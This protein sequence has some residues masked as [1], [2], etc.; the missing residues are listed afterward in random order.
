MRVKDLNRGQLI[1]LK[2]GML[3]DRHEN[4]SYGYLA[5]ADEIISDDEVFDEFSETEFVAEDF[6]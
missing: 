6:V 5:N 4:C 3:C 2:Q 1:Q